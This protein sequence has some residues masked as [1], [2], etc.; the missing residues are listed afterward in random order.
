MTISSKT[1]FA[2]ASAAVS[3]AA[4]ALASPAQAGVK[5]GELNCHVR[6]G[7]GY[8]LGSSKDMDCT[9]SPTRGEPEH[10]VGS[11]SK[12]GVDVGYTHKSVLLW[13][14]VAP[15]SGPQRGALAGGYA[16]V[17]AS[18]AV[19]VGAGA[20]VLVGGFRRSITLQPISVSGEQG[21]NVAAGVGAMRLRHA[22]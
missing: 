8:V 12:F 16:G 17:T 3:L 20:H 11:L 6:G 5:V 7:W 19:G 18:A 14:V 22:S 1:G 2:A 21:L 10:Y 9:F 15:D 13:A 4:F